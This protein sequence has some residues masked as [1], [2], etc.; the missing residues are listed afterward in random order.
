MQVVMQ[1]V[2]HKE[3]RLKSRFRLTSSTQIRAE[4]SDTRWFVVVSIFK[5]L[6]SFGESLQIR[7]TRIPGNKHSN[8]R[9]TIKFKV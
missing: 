5:T 4:E 7:I 8:Y 2:V 6:Y 3:M 9:Y 1:A